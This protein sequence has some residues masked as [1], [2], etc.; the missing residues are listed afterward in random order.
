METLLIPILFALALGQTSYQVY[1]ITYFT[2]GCSKDDISKISLVSSCSPS[3]N[4]T[5]IN[6]RCDGGLECSYSYEYSSF[7][8]VCVRG[9]PVNLGVKAFTLSGTCDSNTVLPLTYSDSNSLTADRNFSSITTW[10]EGDWFTGGLS[11]S[12]VTVNPG[13]LGCNFY[14]L[15]CILLHGRCP[16]F[17]CSLL[18]TNSLAHTSSGCD[19]GEYLECATASWN[20]SQYSSASDLF[21]YNPNRINWPNCSYVPPSPTST[22]NS[23]QP[24]ASTNSA[25]STPT[26]T[27]CT[28][29]IGCACDDELNCDEGLSCGVVS[30]TCN[31]AS[32]QSMALIL[33]AL[34][35]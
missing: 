7:E 33:F 34:L 9:E 3:T 15:S 12:T 26:P 19:A 10:R 11:C 23:A 21:F 6:D 27:R 5:T 22:P 28:R 32:S 20:S 30:F 1:E 13:G 18:R 4:G 35:H 14:I 31:G 8:R 29:S 2:Y 17:D 25:L 16:G 24:S